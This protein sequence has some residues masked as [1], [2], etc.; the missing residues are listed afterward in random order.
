ME[1]FLDFSGG[2]HSLYNELITY[3]PQDCVFTTKEGINHRKK[4]YNALFLLQKNSLNKLLPANL[5][6]PFLDQFTK[7]PGA[8]DLVYSPGHVSFRKMPWIVDFEY[9]LHLS[10]YSFHHFRMYQRVIEKKLRSA[11]CRKII[12]WT[13]ASA[14]TIFELIHDREILDKVEVV[15]LAV[16]A[17]DFPKQWGENTIKFLFVGSINFPDDFDMKGGKE[18]LEAFCLLNRRYDNLE[19]IIRSRVP[20]LIKDQF[21]NIPHIQFIETSLSPEDLDQL[22]QKAD[23]F[24]FPS[25]HTPGLVLLDAMSY[26]LPI[27]TTDVWANHE[28]VENGKN[29]FLIEKSRNISFYLGKSIPNWSNPYNISTIRR[30]TDIRIVYDLAEKMRILI[31][32]EPLRRRMG[33]NG[34]YEILKGKFS[35]GRRNDQ[36]KRIFEEAVH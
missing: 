34:R 33:M 7:I 19:L 17:K 3:P 36:L 9:I 22:F 25:Y 30:H 12:P 15:R 16:H 18:V 35:I 5:Y 11:R 27:I 2:K 21:R 1:I 20:A 4:V 8:A 29:G 6:K 10:G 31:E 24:L 13:S 32:D 14:D 23:I 28:M 26:E